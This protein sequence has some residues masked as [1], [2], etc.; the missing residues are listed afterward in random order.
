VRPAK[1]VG[2]SKVIVTLAPLSEKMACFIVGGGIKVGLRVGTPVGS[3]VGLLVGRDGSNVTADEDTVRVEARLRAVES[4]AAVAAVMILV[5]S[6]VVK[7]VVFDRAE[8]I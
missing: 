5:W 2:T 1:L 4:L 3:V 8:V 7:E 6:A